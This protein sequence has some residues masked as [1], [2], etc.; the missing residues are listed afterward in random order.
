MILITRGAG[1]RSVFSLLAYGL[2]VAFARAL[3]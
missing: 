1:E 3:Q 2:T